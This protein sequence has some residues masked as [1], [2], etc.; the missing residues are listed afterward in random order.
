MGEKNA[1]ETSK[2]AIVWTSADREVALKMAFMYA[3]NAKK[4][5]WWDKVKLVVWGPSAKLLA[6]D[7]DMQTQIYEMKTIGV[8]LAACKACS[9]QY[10]VSETLENLGIE[11]I[12]MGEP[13]T[14]MLKSDWKVL[15]A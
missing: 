15:T 4:N 1:A 11:V 7:K 10:G 2:L 13:L 12:Y 5:G 14:D 9:D 8:E 6:E 3:Y